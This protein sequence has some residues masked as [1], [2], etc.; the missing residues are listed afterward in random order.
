MSEPLD[1]KFWGPEPTR[2]SIAWSYIVGWL[3]GLKRWIRGVWK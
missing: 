3:W 2:L 1:P